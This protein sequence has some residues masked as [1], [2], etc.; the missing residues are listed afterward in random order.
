[1][2]INKYLYEQKQKEKEAKKR[3]RENMVEQKEIRMGLNID[4]HDLKNKGKS[5]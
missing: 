5:C 3:Q 2:E 4:L 1:M